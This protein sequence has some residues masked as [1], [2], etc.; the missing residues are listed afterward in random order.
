MIGISKITQDSQGSIVFQE[1]ITSRFLNTQARVS[2]SPTLDGGSIIDHQGY[3]DSDLRLDIVAELTELQQSI[4]WALYK[5]ESF[6]NISIK[7]G[8][9]KGV[10]SAMFPNEGKIQ[11]TILIQDKLSS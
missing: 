3:S 9:F 2:R 7:E 6:V 1:H 8:F 11:M 10:I 4:L 5:S